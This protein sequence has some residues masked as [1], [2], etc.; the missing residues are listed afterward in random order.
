M[1]HV[2]PGM[3]VGLFGGSFNPPHQGHQLVADIALRRL[4]LDQLWWMVTPGNPL[5]SRRVL[6]PLAE[7]LDL[8]EAMVHDP[9]IRVTAFE[10]SLNSSYTAEVLARVKARNPAVR[11]V[12]IMG[13]DNLRDF[14]RWQNWRKIAMTFPIAVIDRP[15][16]TLAFL[17][18]VMAKTFDYA[19][20][21][22]HDA[23]T[24]G[25]LPAPAWTFIHG[26]RSRLSSTAIRSASRDRQG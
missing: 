13:A 23:G 1:P 22:E 6:A 17:S 4:G 7:R 10:T 12:W 11:F 15:G 8:S 3:L 20:V 16:A 14:H 18:S 2:E 5:K 19:R 24:L 21:D 26:P 25:N 9:R